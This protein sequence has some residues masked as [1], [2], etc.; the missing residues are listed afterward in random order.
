MGKMALYYDEAERLYVREGL[1]PDTII[2]ILGKN[3]SR[4][5]VFNWK[6]DH[7]WEGKRKA[8]IEQFKSLYKE[9]DEGLEQLVR[10]RLRE[11]KANPTSKNLG[12]LGVAISLL[13]KNRG[14]KL[15]KDEDAGEKKGGKGIF[16]PEAVEEAIQGLYGLRT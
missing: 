3:V 12:A 1:S 10:D 7:D 16:S 6:K 4:K 9:L 15:L 11:C 2:G 8:R 14:K 13:E 5:T